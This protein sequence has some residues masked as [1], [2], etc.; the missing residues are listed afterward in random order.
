M[1]VRTSRIARGKLAKALVLRGG[2]EKTSSG[3]R[4]EDL[5]KNKRGKIVSK[6]MAQRGRIAFKFISK[7]TAAVVAARK[8]LAL[9][10]FVPINGKSR[11]GKALY[12]KAKSLYSVAP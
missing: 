12:A 4:K 2:K 6:K 3:L 5:L 8:A 11:E 7:W 9:M 1:G 10:G